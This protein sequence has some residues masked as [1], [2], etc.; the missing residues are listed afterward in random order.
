M[1]EYFH[2]AGVPGSGGT[3]IDDVIKAEG[4]LA[5]KWGLTSSLPSDHTYKNSAP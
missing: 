2:V 5:H 1:A 4:Y 3:N